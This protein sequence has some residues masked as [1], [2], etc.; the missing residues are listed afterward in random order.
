MFKERFRLDFGV[1]L[2]EGVRSCYERVDWILFLFGDHADT[3]ACRSELPA[4]ERNF[5]FITNAFLFFSFFPL[6]CGLM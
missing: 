1:S 4:G 5:E 2:M 3:C 6:Y